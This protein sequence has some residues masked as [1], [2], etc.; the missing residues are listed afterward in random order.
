MELVRTVQ[1]L[2]HVSRLQLVQTDGAV[3]FVTLRLLVL[4]IVVLVYY[5]LDLVGRQLDLLVV[6]VHLLTTSI[7]LL[8][9]LLLLLLIGLLVGLLVVCA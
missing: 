5:L 1:R 9:V 4:E 3:V 7:I 8:L 2:H 6:V